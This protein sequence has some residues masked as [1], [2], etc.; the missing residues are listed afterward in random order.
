MG[1]S[2]KSNLNFKPEAPTSV[3][4]LVLFGAETV[5]L[6]VC[7]IVSILYHGQTGVVLG[8]VLLAAALAAI[9]G[10]LL[11]INAIAKPDKSHSLAVTGLILN[12]LFL[13]GE[14]ALYVFGASQYGGPFV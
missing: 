3:A 7:Y 9:A 1:R 6:L 4:S 5:T 13:I 2:H 10:I 8:I 12:G 14:I 11:A